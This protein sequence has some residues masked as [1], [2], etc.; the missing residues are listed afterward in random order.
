MV[1][2]WHKSSSPQPLIEISK[3]GVSSTFFRLS[4]MHRTSVWGQE[5]MDALQLGL[6]EEFAEVWDAYI[7]ALKIGHI[8]ITDKED[9]LVWQHNPHGIYTPKLGYTQLNIDL[10]HQEP[11]WWWKGVWKIKFPLKSKLF[12]WCLIRNKVPT[13]DIMK[14]IGLE[15]RVGVHS[16]SLMRNQSHTFSSFVLLYF[17]YGQNVQELLVRTIFGKDK[18]LKRPGECGYTT[19]KIII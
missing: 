13:W 4:D 8:C 12:L 17:R 18:T 15:G 19:P 1:G 2:Q 9:E 7:R 10:H 5:W 11:S 14:H 16:A 3:T 6:G